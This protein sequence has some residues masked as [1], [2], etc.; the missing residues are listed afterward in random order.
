LSFS[1]GNSG[2]YYWC[3]VVS[4]VILAFLLAEIMF[5]AVMGDLKKRKL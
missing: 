1:H 4:A 5:T 3:T 2:I